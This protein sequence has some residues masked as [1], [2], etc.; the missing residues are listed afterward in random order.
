MRGLELLPMAV[1]TL[2]SGVWAL[3][4]GVPGDVHG[5]ALLL[6]PD[7]RLG[8]YAR[9]PGQVQQLQVAVGQRVQAGQTLATINRIDQVAPGGGVRGNGSEALQLQEAAIGRQRQAL[10]LAITNLKRSNG[11]IGSQVR[12]LE[13]LRRDEVIPRYS[14]LWVGAQDL[15][16]RNQSQLSLLQSQVAELEATLAE[17]QAQRASQLVRAPAAGVVLSLS[18]AP[19][20]ALLA[21]QRI[22]MIGPGPAPTSQPRRAMALFTQAD[23]TRLR[24]GMTLL[25]EPQLQTRHLYGGTN[26]RY[27]SV[28]GRISAIAPAA[29]DLDEVSRAVGSTAL[30][31]SLLANSHQEAFGEGG[32]PL[33]TLGDK[34]TAPMVL[35]TVALQSAATPS[36]LRWSEG[37]GPDLPLENGTPASAKVDVDRRS[38]LSYALPFV[39]WLTGVER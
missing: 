11:P 4:P 14:P 20:Q 16:L 24:P 22:A 37:Q 25:L 23:A 32:N 10:L 7:S 27:G 31:T 30:A 12:A 9:S 38:A 2:A 17:L 35:V 28:I 18:A 13:A 3:L 39:R 29:A 8:V 6:E 34:A 5:G 19:G 33:A 26:Q 15:Y 21:G 36:G 1:V